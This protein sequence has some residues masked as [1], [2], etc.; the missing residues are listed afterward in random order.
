MEHV[1]LIAAIVLSLAIFL[2]WD[3]F[4]VDRRPVPP[5]A[6]PVETTERAPEKPD[7][8][9]GSITGEG[10][11]T[12]PPREE[13]PA[14]V[15][16]HTF[17]TISVETGLYKAVISDR[18]AAILR[19]DLK[20]YRENPEPGAPHMAMIPESNRMGSALVALSGTDEPLVRQIFATDFTGRELRV[21]N[22]PETLSFFWQ[23]GNG[24]IL[25]KRY[26]FYPDKYNIDMTVLVR[27]ESEGIIDRNLSITMTNPPPDDSKRFTFSGPFIFI[28]RDLNQ[29]KISDIQEKGTYSGSIQWAGIEDNYF[30]TAL[31]PREATNTSVVLDVD[32]RNN[33]LKSTF[34][35]PMDPLTP[36]GVAQFDYQLFMGPKKLS[37]LQDF[38]YE[39]DRIVDFGIFSVIA[40][41][42]LWLMN[43]IHD[44][45]IA[46]Y[47]IA[48][49]LLTLL[50]KAV[51][52]PLGNKSYKSMGEMRKIQPLMME[53]RNKYKDDKKKMNEE[54]MNL[55]KTYKINPLSGCLPMVVQIPVFIAFYRMLY[56]AIELRHAPFMLWINDLSAPD[57]LFDFNVTIPLM[58]Q[59]AGIP[60]LT[61]IMG[62]TMFL[63]QKLAPPPGD[64]MQARIMMMLPIVFTFIFINFPAGLVLYWLVNNVVSIAQ[65]YNVNRK[66]TQS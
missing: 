20:E 62:A 51:F 17:E 29:I 26:T 31:I 61:I 3:F 54:V 14:Q 59:P 41:P 1:R 45:I 21:E 9:P 33:L 38:G 65:Q 44:N 27:N 2:V 32:A 7:T 48:I 25:E 63:Q 30:M 57:R 15:P 49:I 34:Q 24:L 18:G 23:S 16:D 11:E 5:S 37:L 13:L 52:W 42:A 55:Y 35:Q 36:G 53:I 56:E 4:F 22:A 60:V 39:L 50:I 19:F 43:A 8:A 12:K 6:P 28:D 40:K 66:I 64:P 46:N 47:G 58:A 10:M